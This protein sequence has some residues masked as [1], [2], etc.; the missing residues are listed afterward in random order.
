MHIK[1]ISTLKRNFIETNNCWDNEHL[2]QGYV[3]YNVATVEPFSTE[4]GTYW[5]KLHSTYR[6][7]G[8]F[9]LLKTPFVI[10][11]C[12]SPCLSPIPLYMI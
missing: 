3:M 5:P 9:C 12:F 8:F 4:R 7:S 10:S 1:R 2:G 11:A 6:W